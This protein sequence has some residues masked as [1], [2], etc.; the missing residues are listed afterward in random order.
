MSKGNHEDRLCPVCAAEMIMEACG[1][2]TC[3]SCGY[4]GRPSN[5][6]EGKLL[7]EGW[8]DPKDCAVS[9][10]RAKL[11]HVIIDRDCGHEDFQRVLIIAKSESN[12]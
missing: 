6:H 8:L 5:V 1:C 11:V 3:E 7:L 4:V 9:G 12:V 10:D 2:W